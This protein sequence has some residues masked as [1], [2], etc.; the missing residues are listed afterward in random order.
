[1]TFTI[2]GRRDGSQL[3]AVGS[4]PVTFSFWLIKGPGGFAFLGS[5][6]DHGLAEFLIVLHRSD[7]GDHS[8]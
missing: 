4:I 1:V 7:A 6:A 3:E 2:A 5:L 8:G